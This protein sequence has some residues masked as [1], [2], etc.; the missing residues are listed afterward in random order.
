MLPEVTERY[1]QRAISLSIQRINTLRRAFR[2]EWAD[3]STLMMRASLNAFGHVDATAMY[4]AK[5]SPNRNGT[6]EIQAANYNNEGVYIRA[7]PYYQ[8][9]Q[10]AAEIPSIYTGAA[11]RSSTCRTTTSAQ[12]ALPLPQGVVFWAAI[13]HPAIYRQNGSCGGIG[14]ELNES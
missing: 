3:Y 11:S 5:L 9:K 14:K 12:R 2:K 6:A 7:R 4:D 10:N 8:A 1:E 13:R